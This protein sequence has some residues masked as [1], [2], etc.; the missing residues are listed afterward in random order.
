MIKH[1]ITKYPNYQIKSYKEYNNNILIWEENY[2]EQGNK[3]GKNNSFSWGGTNNEFKE[4]IYYKHGI[5]HGMANVLDNNGNIFMEVLYLNGKFHGT[6]KVYSSKGLSRT[7]EYVKGKLHG[8]FVFYK[9][10]N[11][12]ERKEI[13]E[14]DKLIHTTKY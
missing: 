5:K 8:R 3:H 10:N 9:N 14:N 1:V 6:L 12:I 7:I 13:Y 2:D 11:I 4:E